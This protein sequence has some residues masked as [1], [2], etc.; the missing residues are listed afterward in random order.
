MKNI[1]TIILSLS[2][3]ALITLIAC[4]DNSANQNPDVE[5]AFFKVGEINPSHGESFILALEKAEDIE[6]ARSIINDPENAVDKIVYAKIV[7]QQGDEEYKNRDLNS[8]LVWSWKIEEFKEF[9]FNTIE[10][11]DG[12][13]GYVQEDLTRWFLN[14]SG[15]STYGLI[16]FWGYTVVEELELQPLK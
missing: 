8:G 11:L 13:P 12:W 3:F 4:K 9:A 15:D 1:K 14:T 16:G 2:I 5:V 6:K 7:K 10:I